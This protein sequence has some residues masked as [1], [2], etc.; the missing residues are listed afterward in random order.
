MTQ[1]RE[2]QLFRTLRRLPRLSPLSSQFLQPLEEQVQF[3]FTGLSGKTA[4]TNRY[5]SLLPQ[6]S[7]IC[8][9]H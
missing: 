2:R 5:D 1:I 3:L 9:R 7:I 4:A 6:V 8:Q